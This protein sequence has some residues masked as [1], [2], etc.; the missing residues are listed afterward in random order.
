[1]AT[2]Q[3]KKT[4]R[5][6]PGNTLGSRS[7]YRGGRPPRAKEEKYLRAFNRAVTYDKWVKATNKMLEMALAGNIGAYRVLAKYAM[8]EPTKDIK[9]DIGLD[10][11][12]LRTMAEVLDKVYGSESD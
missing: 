4:G 10:K 6:L 3:D 7:T 1:M 8:P 12:S 9:M 2:G 5:F 11:P